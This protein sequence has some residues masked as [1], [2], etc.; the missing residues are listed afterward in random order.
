MFPTN[1]G[2]EKPKKKYDW[3]EADSKKDKE[4]KKKEND[5]KDDEEKMKEK[6]KEKV[7]IILYYK[8]RK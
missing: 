7:Y 2:M 4:E 1:F 5:K 8:Y 6:E 3:F